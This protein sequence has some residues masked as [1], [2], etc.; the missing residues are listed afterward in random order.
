MAGTA[1]NNKQERGRKK[2]GRK[3]RESK[4]GS[5]VGGKGNK[6]IMLLMVSLR[7]LKR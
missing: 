3:E 7:A 5:N 4:A 6:G 2:K 1:E